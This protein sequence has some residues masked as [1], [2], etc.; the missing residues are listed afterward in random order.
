MTGRKPCTT[1][2]PTGM[3][4]RG[5]TSSM[6]TAAPMSGLQG[7]QKTSARLFSEYEAKCP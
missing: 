5:T 6:V 7:I 4:S 3:P 1:Q 2:Q